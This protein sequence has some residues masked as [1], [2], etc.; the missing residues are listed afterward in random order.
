MERF[1]LFKSS[2]IGISDVDDNA[3]T[4]TRTRRD[5]H[6]PTTDFR[7]DETS[8]IDTLVSRGHTG[9]DTFPHANCTNETRDAVCDD[10]MAS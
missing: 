8:I 2:L 1:Y 5:A 3:K 9:N 7:Y 4:L 10:Q 6:T